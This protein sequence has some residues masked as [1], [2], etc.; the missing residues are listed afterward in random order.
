MRH[1]VFSRMGQASSF[2]FMS[3]TEIA[4]S[5]GR[6]SELPFDF[7]ITRKLE[8]ALIFALHRRLPL[9]PHS[10]SARQT[11]SIYVP[12]PSRSVALACSAIQSS[13]LACCKKGSLNPF[14]W[15]LDSFN[16]H[17]LRLLNNAMILLLSFSL[18][19]SK[20]WR[21]GEN[22]TFSPYVVIQL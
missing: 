7:C 5:L 18:S 10:S 6:D 22:R 4:L 12:S 8:F 17:S 16:P 19:T 20:I 21:S 9:A 11:G 1:R 2:D 14:L 13:A 15:Y 3:V